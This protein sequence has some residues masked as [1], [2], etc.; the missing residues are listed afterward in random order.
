MISPERLAALEASWLRLLSE[1][2]VAPARA[3]PV[4]DELAARYGEP[5]RHYHTLEHLAE[6]L[7]VLGRLKPQCHDFASASLALWFHDAIS[8]PLAHDNEERS[9]EF[10]I[11]KLAA[12]GIAADVTDRVAGIIRRTNHSPARNVDADTRAVLDADLAILGASPV[13]YDRY[14][15]DI[16]TEYAHVPEADYRAGRA[17][18]LRAFLARP[19]IYAVPVMVEEGEAAA[20]ANL[21]RELAV[22]EAV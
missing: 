22:L 9:A 19:Q 5:H 7:R 8:D 12:L 2:D 14:A 10:A 6:T 4:F 16:R 11:E 18:I 21:R 1:Y 17:K 15:A 3:L 20:R 13:R